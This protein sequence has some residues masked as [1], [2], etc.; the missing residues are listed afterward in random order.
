M[1]YLTASYTIRGAAAAIVPETDGVSKQRTSAQ[2]ARYH[3][4]W[5]SYAVPSIWE[6]SLQSTL[7]ELWCSHARREHCDVT[8]TVMNLNYHAG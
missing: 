4:H 6:L 2:M 3:G 5:I 1:L 8:V 7:S